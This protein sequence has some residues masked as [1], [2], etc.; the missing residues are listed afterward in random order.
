MP[1]N[2]IPFYKNK[3]ILLT[4]GTGFLGKMIIEKLLRTCDVNKIYVIVRPKKGLTPKER[5]QK[6]FEEPVFEKV[7]SS[8]IKKILILEG[9]LMEMNIGLSKKDEEII[10]NE[11]NVV[12]H[13]GAFLNM[14]SKLHEAVITNVRGTL[15]ILDLMKDA[16]NLNSLILVSTAYSNCH[17]S[18]IKEEF[19]G[20]PIDPKFLIKLVDKLDENILKEISSRL[21]GKWP[22]S[23]V[24]TKAVAESLLTSKEYDIPVALFRPAIVTPTAIEPISGWSDNLYGP[25]GILLSA[26]CGI[27]RVIRGD[28]NLKSHTVP[29]DMCINALLCFAWDLDRKWKSGKISPPVMNFSAKN[30]KLLIPMKQYIKLGMIDYAPFKKAIW[31]QMLFMIKNK[32]VYD[33]MKFLLHT[34]PAYLIDAMLIISLRKPR[35]KKIYSQ[36]DKTS[37]VLQYFLLREWGIDNDNVK[38]LWSKLSTE[39][40]IVFNFDIDSIDIENYFRNMAICLKKFILKEDITKLD[41][42]RKRHDRLKILH[43]TLKYSLTGLAMYS[44]FRAVTRVSNRYKK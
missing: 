17:E 5:L 28:Y 6:L 9:D 12:F 13:C 25:L 11:V 22:N 26:H 40:R 15:A 35:M 4:G 7:R 14:D 38:E 21:I 31:Y 18:Q 8:N 39:D 10:K 30:T 42:H 3:N 1:S 37:N 19:Y 24:F 33:F 2:I 32:Y 36:V 16:K 20:A 44:I 27:L 29:G 23:Y 34:I 43:Y 41:L